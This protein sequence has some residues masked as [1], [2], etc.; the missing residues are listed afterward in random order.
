MD[1]RVSAVNGAPATLNGVANP[2][3]NWTIEGGGDT[4]RVETDAVSK[5]ITVTA[6]GS[7]V[8]AAHAYTP[9]Y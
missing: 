4:V 2:C 6:T 7:A 9:F 5:K 1:A 3:G 8:P